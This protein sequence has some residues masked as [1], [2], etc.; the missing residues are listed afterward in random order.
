MAIH[1]VAGSPMLKAATLSLE[2]RFH[3]AEVARAAAREILGPNA[4]V[5]GDWGEW[6]A[7]GAA[8]FYD[9]QADIQLGISWGTIRELTP[10]T[11]MPWSI[12]QTPA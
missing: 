8:H 2:P 1:L 4:R 6:Y 11:W 9:T 7:S 10:P 3:E 5:G 12:A